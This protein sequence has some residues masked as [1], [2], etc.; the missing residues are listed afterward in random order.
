MNHFQILEKSKNSD[1]KKF[2]SKC[3]LTVL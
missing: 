2:K 3:P 1:L